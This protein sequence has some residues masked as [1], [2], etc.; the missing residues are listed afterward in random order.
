MRFLLNVRAGVF[1]DQTRHALC[2]DAARLGTGRIRRRQFCLEHGQYL[3]LLSRPHERLG[4]WTQRSRRGIY[5]QNAGLMWLL[6]LAIAVY[7]AFFYMNNLVTARSTFKDQLAIVGRKHTWIMSFINI[8]TFSSFFGY[9]AAFPRL[10]KMLYPAVTQS[11]SPFLG[12]W[13]VRCRDRSA[14]G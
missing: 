3:F 9:S 5:I 2:N 13:S 11:A 10:I 4:A 6:P 8:G 1:R 14:A 12:R 7:G